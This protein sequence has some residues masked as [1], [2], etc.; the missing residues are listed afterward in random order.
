MKKILWISSCAPSRKAKEAGGQTFQYYFNGML[1]DNRFEI[2]LIS[3]GDVNRRSELES[4]FKQIK[5]K[6]IYS[7]KSAFSKIK[8]ISNIESTFNP[9]NKYA[10]LISNY[11]ASAMVSTAKKYRDEGYTPDIIIL[12]WTNIVVLEK[13]IHKIFPDSM[14]V[15]S[16]HDVTFVGYERKK[17][18]Y[19]GLKRLLWKIKYN[20]EKRIELEALRGCELVLPHNADNKKVLV[21]EGINPDKIM[22]LVPYYNDM[23]RYTRKSNQ[24][25]ILFFG[26]MA[27][28]ENSLSALWFIDN[29]L[30]LLTDINIRFVILGSNPTAELKEKESSRIHVTGFVDSVEPYFEESM[31]LVAPL[32]LGAGI[33][34]KILEAMSSGI[35]VITNDIG[36][37]GIPAVDGKHYYHCTTPQEY[38]NMIRKIYNNELDVVCLEENAK[39]LLRKHFSKEGVSPKVLKYS[40]RVFELVVEKPALWEYLLFAEVLK[41]NLNKLDDLRYDMKYGISF[42]RT[43]CFENPIE[44]FDYVQAKSK[45]LI[46][47]ND[48]L[49]VILNK[50]LK[51]A[52]GERGTPG[53]A[54]Y[55]IYVAEKLIEVYKSDH[56]WALDFK[57]ISVP[58]M[59]EKL[60]EYTS[61]LSKSII[62]DIENFIDDYDKR[63]NELAYGLEDISGEKVVSF[64]LELRSPD[65]NKIDAEIK[66]LGEILLNN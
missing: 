25:D 44:I 1:Q 19:T 10:N 20:N 47:K 24:R 50:A 15:A 9:W 37:E 35:P 32:V 6:F 45:E 26:A 22:G 43:V 29:V 64:N 8:K 28:M 4:E 51:E 39:K 42:E 36:I 41:D 48:I 46:R 31:C 55:I 60:I 11:S 66:R 58:E 57:C 30:P 53:N 5:S 18:Y 61:E 12:E 21:D 27:R 2:R 7:E 63:I 62:E 40:G 3:L 33:K 52:L 16:E 65:M 14:I 13:Q 49:C 34:V 23:S 17:E 38:A 59:F 54:E 56:L